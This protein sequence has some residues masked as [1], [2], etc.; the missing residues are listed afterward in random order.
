VAGTYRRLDAEND[1]SGWGADT[2][3]TDLRASYRTGRLELSGGLGEIR[4]ERDADRLVTSG[5]RQDLFAIDYVVDS[6]FL[7][8]GVR[9]ASDGRWALGGDLRSYEND[10]SFPLERDD[11]RIYAEIRLD[12]SYTLDVGY[13]SIEYSEDAFDAY[14]AELLEVGIRLSW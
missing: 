11:L 14:D 13:R 3:Q 2:E 8:L 12:G 1:G 6:A 4:N 5:T 10:G 9:W 7:D